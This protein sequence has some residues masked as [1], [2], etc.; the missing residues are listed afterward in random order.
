[1]NLFS[2]LRFR[3]V[4][5]DQGSLPPAVLR[6]SRRK[7]MTVSLKRP[8]D[9]DRL[10]SRVVPEAPGFWSEN[11]DELSRTTVEGGNVKVLSK[12]KCQVLAERNG[13]S[14]EHARGYVDG[15]TFRQRAKKPSPYALVGIDDYS[16]GFRAA[17]YERRNGVS[18][19]LPRGGSPEEHAAEKV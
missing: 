13:W 4:A 14:L 19:A 9:I 17:Y 5:E 15:E 1:M 10:M 3:A 11:C 12:Q 6:P 8:V 2:W 18:K 16:L 7:A